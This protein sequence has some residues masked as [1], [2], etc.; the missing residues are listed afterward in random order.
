MTAA[1]HQFSNLQHSG[2]VEKPQGAASV[3]LESVTKAKTPKVAKKTKK[4]SKKGEVAS[5]IGTNDNER[6]S[7]NQQNATGTMNGVS[8][9]V[10]RKR[11]ASNADTNDAGKQAPEHNVKSDDIKL[12]GLCTIPLQKMQLP[13]SGE[14]QEAVASN[15]TDVKDAALNAASSNVA[16]QQAMK[17]GGRTGQ[18]QHGGPTDERHNAIVSGSPSQQAAHNMHN[19]FL[20]LRGRGRGRSRGPAS[21]QFLGQPVSRRH[22]VNVGN[23]LPPAEHAQHVLPARFSMMRGHVRGRPRGSYSAGGAQQ[24]G[25]Y[26]GRGGA[27]VHGRVQQRGMPVHGRVI[28]SVHCSPHM[29]VTSGSDGNVQSLKLVSNSGCEY[30]HVLL[31]TSGWN[32]G[33]LD[34]A[35]DL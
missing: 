27:M 11:K 8:V 16:S 29:S 5:P 34:V 3:A 25:Q 10:N 13:N 23:R 17:V 35:L 2:N 31:F 15:E 32:G 33:L 21:V 7:A 22:Y 1:R 30:L 14:S 6:N 24:S 20:D 26:S 12:Q 28:A 19:K 18:P 9:K 4:S